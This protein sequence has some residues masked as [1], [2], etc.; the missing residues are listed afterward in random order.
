VRVAA[1]MDLSGLPQFTISEVDT[2][3][4]NGDDFTEITGQKLDSTVTEWQAYPAN[5][6]AGRAAR[7]TCRRLTPR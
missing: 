5:S 1:I 2:A 3:R 6:D 4:A 7:E